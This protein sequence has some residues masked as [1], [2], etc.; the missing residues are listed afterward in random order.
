MLHCVAGTHADRF[1]G[2]QAVGA[3]HEADASAPIAARDQPKAAKKSKKKKVQV[4]PLCCEYDNVR[5]LLAGGMN[6]Y[7]CDAC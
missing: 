2:T 7:A 6:T 3:D 5:A 1:V 4:S